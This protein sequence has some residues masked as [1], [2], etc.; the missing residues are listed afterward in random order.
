MC[1][2]S[3]YTVRDVKNPFMQSSAPVDHA[4]AAKQWNALRD[5]FEQAGVSVET[6]DPVEDLEDMVFA[7]NQA[8]VGSSDSY[9]KFFVPS[10]MRYESR[11]R[12]VPY[13]TS[14][15]KKHGFN[16]LNLFLKA[17]DQFLE[18]HGDLL[19]HP[20]QPL[21]WAGYGFRSSKAGVARFAEAMQQQDVT[22]VPLELVDETFYH[23]D[24]CFAPL[25]GNA[26]I[27]YPGA[28]SESATAT[29][30]R[31]WKRL[32]EVSREDALQFVCNGIT[33]NGYFLA[34]HLPDNVATIVRNEGLKPVIVDTSEFEKAGGSV[35]CMK[36]F[37]D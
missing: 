14:W 9:G 23:L 15:F 21:V 19:W 29:L 31:G 22:V 11:E 32:Y 20:Q 8:F 16:S 36:V 2:P 18:G 5:A 1:P 24:T 30:R 28:L 37:L 4:L 26:A 13:Y 35:F 27:V 10:R 3:F 12:E 25:N 17:D 34:S 33:V 6:I 7:A